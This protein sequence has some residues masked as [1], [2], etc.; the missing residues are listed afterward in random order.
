MSKIINVDDEFDSYDEVERKIKELQE[1][2]KSKLWKRDSR[3]IGAAI[4][5]MPKRVGSIKVKQLL[6]LLLI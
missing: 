5:R 2:E 3:T 1:T 4:K 6:W